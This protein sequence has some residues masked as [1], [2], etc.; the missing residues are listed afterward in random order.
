M[1]EHVN[2]TFHPTGK[3]QILCERVKLDGTPIRSISYDQRHA[4]YIAGLSP[5][6]KAELD[7]AIEMEWG[8]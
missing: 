7:L 1:V 2:I 4:G 6:Q 5:S 8:S 3:G